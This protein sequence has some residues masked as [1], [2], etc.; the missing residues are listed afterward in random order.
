MTGIVW[1]DDAQVC[2]GTTTKRYGALEGVWA[3]ITD[4]AGATTQTKHKP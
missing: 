3:V 4:I 2:T 1:L